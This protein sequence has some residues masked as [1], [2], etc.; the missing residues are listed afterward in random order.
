MA[1][2]GRIISSSLDLNKVYEALGMEI[3]K[4]IPCDRLSVNL[5]YLELGVRSTVWV[6]GDIV[7]VGVHGEELPL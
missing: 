7:R 2:I 3:Q 5:V 6:S 4:M 1:E